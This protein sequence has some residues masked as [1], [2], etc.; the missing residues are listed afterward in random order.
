MSQLNSSQNINNSKN[1]AQISHLINDI[2]H[3]IQS[4][5][6]EEVPL[7]SNRHRPDLTYSI[8]HNQQVQ[9][10]KNRLA[11]VH[12]ADIAELL[13][14]LPQQQRH[15]IWDTIEGD[16]TGEILLEVSD[17]VRNTLLSRMQADDLLSATE[18]LDSDEIAD[19][20][21]DLPP[22]VVNKILKQLNPKNRRQLEEALSYKEGT[23]GALMDFN[24]ITIREDISIKGIL[25]YCQ[26]LGDL[27]EKT[28]QMF[29]VD[30]HNVLK[31]SLPLQK[32]VATPRHQLVSSVMN[33][34]I[35]S[36][37][38]EGSADKAVQA[39]DR[40]ELITAPVIDEQHR[41]IGRLSVDN[42]IDYA[43]EQSEDELLNQAGLSEDEDMFSGV[44][45][46]AKNR[47]FW[48]AMN[49]ATAFLA[50][51]VISL[52]EETIIQLVALA[53]LMPVVAAVGGNTGNQTSMLVIRSLALD[54]LNA[55]NIR[56]ML[57]KEIG[58]S[59]ING[60]LWGSIMAVFVY[61]VYQ[62]FNLGLVMM[63]AIFL[64]LFLSTLAG[65]AVPIIRHHYNLDP[66]MGTSV[67][68]TFL[69]DSIGFFIFLGL[70][71]T[72]L[73]SA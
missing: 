33:K 52:F 71:A 43:R 34:D 20:A 58:I 61:F 57:Y 73:I 30:R 51:R 12:P 48:L 14:A 64:S 27:P 35:V 53:T 3:L 10:I 45:K 55:S 69:A 40:Y 29:V 60:L 22:K 63:S 1:K 42:I 36:F 32:L 50:T 15:Y 19:L 11:R 44:W 18:K 70:A 6:L 46:G 72:F 17:A 38:P 49:L 7:S 37:S 68:L 65:I 66:A 4:Q 2:S 23:V 5:Q 31:G 59:L 54:Q 24:M 39:F 62:N 26:R 56:Q 47:W 28:H 8:L 13:E 25:R 21:P 16:K 67:I 41:L 9:R